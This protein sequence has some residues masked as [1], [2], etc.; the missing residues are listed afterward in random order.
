MA[1][2]CEIEIKDASQ[3]SLLLTLLGI[4]ALF[5][6]LEI[7]VGWYAEST[8]LIADSLDMLAD[9]IVY[10]IAFYAIGRAAHLKANAALLSGY[11]QLFLAALVGLEVLRRSWFGSDPISEL[12]MLMG[13]LALLANAYCLKLIFKHRHGEVHMRASWIF[14]AN[15]VIANLGVILSGLLVF[16]LQSRLPDLIIGGLIT[17]FILVGAIRIIRDAQRERKPKADTCCSG[18]TCQEDNKH[19]QQSS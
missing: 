8:G 4:N 6:L 7:G 14:S 13:L 12:M 15:D 10:G 19:E 1:C 16:W 5:F 3:K 9:A 11:F 2:Q 18:S 17:L